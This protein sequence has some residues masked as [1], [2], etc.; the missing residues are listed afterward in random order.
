MKKI[1]KFIMFFFL[2]CL[3]WGIS[4]CT[5]PSE[6]TKVD[7]S[8]VNDI[9][10]RLQ[11]TPSWTAIRDYLFIEFK[12]GLSRTEVHEILNKVGPWAID[13]AD[14]P[15]T[16]G[17]NSASGNGLYRENIHFTENNTFHALGYWGF[18][19]DKNGIL[20]HQGPIDIN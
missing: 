9:A 3:M 15:E 7:E 10:G 14:S 11:V 17:W 12:P 1:G 18:I 2:V 6:K 13:L 16:G 5:F 4:G 20:D 8:V 19:Y